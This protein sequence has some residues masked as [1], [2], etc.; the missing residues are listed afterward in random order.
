MFPS[1]GL[2]F[3]IALEARNLRC[4][5]SRAPGRP[6][7]HVDMVEYAIISLRGERADQPLCES[8]EILASVERTRTVRFR[9]R[10]IEV[11]D[12]DQVE[13]GARRHLAT[14]ELAECKDCDL[15]AGHAAV[16]PRKIV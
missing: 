6:Q 14:A 5:R 4:Q 8:R 1:P 3:L 10:G 13:I 15:L 7:S 16:Q 11:V 2:F 9:T 12:H